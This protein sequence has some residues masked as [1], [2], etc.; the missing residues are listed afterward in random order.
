MG[1]DLLG[2]IEFDNKALELIAN[3]ALLTLQDQSGQKALHYAAKKGSCAVVS[4][5][6]AKGAEVN[7]K[8]NKGFTALHAA[9]LRGDVEI[10]KLLIAASAKIDKKSKE[11]RKTPLHLAAEHGH[12]DVYAELVRNGADENKLDA[13]GKS[14]ASYAALLSTSSTKKIKLTTPAENEFALHDA[15]KNGNEFEV[16]SLLTELS[17]INKQDGQG[18]TPLDYACENGHLNIVTTLLGK[19]QQQVCSFARQR[20]TQCCIAPAAPQILIL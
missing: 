3:G 13:M 5:L 2:R 6:L 11:D 17:D 20:E 14:A 12:A 4:A 9:S 7:A 1:F 16:M 18:Y 19:D 15:C 10:V 8:D